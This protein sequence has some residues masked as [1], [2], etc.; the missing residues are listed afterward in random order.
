M[1][2]EY[3]R[4]I[5]NSF[6]D[7]LARGRLNFDSL[8]DFLAGKVSTSGTA[9][10]RGATRR[11]TFTNNF[12][13]FLQDDWKI[14]P[15]LTLNLGMRYEYLGIFR[16]QGDRLSNFIPARGWS[17]WVSPAWIVCTNR[18][19]TTS[20]RDSVSRMTLPGAA[21]RFFAAGTVF[22]TIRLHRTTSCC[23]A[24]RTAA[25]ESGS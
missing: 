9:V 8:A 22:I 6:N 20:R 2:G 5:V 4:A 3:R 16:E 21:A 18:T 17:E 1:G 23:R 19:T 13:L 24:S 10:L 7:Q 12:G 14:T 15:R 11:D 25:P